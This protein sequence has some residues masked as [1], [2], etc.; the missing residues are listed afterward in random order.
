MANENAI[1]IA[2]IVLLLAVVGV[3][4]VQWGKGVDS[5]APA[6]AQEFMSAEQ[7]AERNAAPAPTD[8]TAAPSGEGAEPVG[9]GLA[10]P[11]GGGWAEGEEGP[12]GAENA[13]PSGL[14]GNMPEGAGWAQGE[15]GP[16][17]GEGRMPD[18]EEPAGTSVGLCWKKPKAGTTYSYDFSGTVTTTGFPAEKGKE[19]QDYAV[20]ATDRPI[21]EWKSGTVVEVYGVTTG[22]DPE[23]SLSVKSDQ[24]K[25]YLCA[26]WPASLDEFQS[27]R[28]ASCTSKAL[29]GGKGNTE[30]HGDLVLEPRPLPE[31]LLVIGGDRF[32]SG[33][34]RA[35]LVRVDVSG[36]VEAAGVPAGS[37]LVAAA[38]S[39]ILDDQ[40]SE[41]DPR[42]VRITEAD[43]EFS[44]S[45]LAPPG[46]K[47]YLCAMALP[48]GE[49]LD[50]ITSIEGQ[51]CTHAI[52]PPA[53]D[54]EGVITIIGASIRVN[55]EKMPLAPHEQDHL[56]LVGRCS[57]DS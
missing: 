40:E 2:A 13:G 42:T 1:R 41:D 22:R 32:R 50:R 45:Y 11:A 14:G 10:L 52:E 38:S 44:L 39:P 53:A 19:P 23:F 49:K 48:R 5:V 29:G 21:S 4:Y 56:S 3:S 35:G 34:P 6:P 24:S 20:I 15:I 47:L 12:E 7:L 33:P 57:G 54:K 8:A 37:F 9:T 36:K 17:G 26:V 27:L 18:G 43:G 55:A 25:L 46:E 31:V 28:I 16:E 30:K 51:G